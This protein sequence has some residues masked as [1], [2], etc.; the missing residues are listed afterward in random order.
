MEDQ[1]RVDAVWVW[2]FRAF[3]S[4][5]SQRQSEALSVCGN[6]SYTSTSVLVTA[7]AE[8]LGSEVSAR[9]KTVDLQPYRVR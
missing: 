1:F 2:K 3:I 4:D 8:K 6:A 5:S 9:K 7:E